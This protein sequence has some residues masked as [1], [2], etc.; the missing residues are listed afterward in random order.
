MYSPLAISYL[1]LILGIICI[2]VYFNLPEKINSSSIS[3]W[4]LIL[5]LIYFI[6]G[7]NRLRKYFK[8]KN[9]D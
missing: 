9:N 5:S 6:L 7:G 8:N 1:Y 4:L 3:H 2:V